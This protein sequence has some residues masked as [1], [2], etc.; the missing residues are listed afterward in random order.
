MGSPRRITGLLAVAAIALVLLSAGGCGGSSESTA[1][2]GETEAA[3]A[4]YRDYLLESAEKLTT[5][6]TQLRNK[7]KL[8]IL[9]GAESRYSSSL[10]P[11]G[12]LRPALPLFPSLSKRLVD[13]KAGAFP[14]I[15]RILWKEQETGHRGVVEAGR[16]REAV[17]LLHEQAKTVPLHTSAI[18]ANAEG[19]LREIADVDL[20][21]RATPYAQI[22]LNPTS[23]NLE[24]VEAAY[25]AVKP[26]A[27][28]TDPDLAKEISREFKAAFTEL[29]RYGPPAHNLK[30]IRPSSPGTAFITTENEQIKPADLQPLAKH[31]AHL[32]SL[33]K[34][35][36]AAVE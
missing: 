11:L 32:Q 8:E 5:W 31:I 35:L 25:A 27:L 9:G 33:F 7:F 4:A 24:G 14:R 16:A 22:D 12:H 13:T 15:E 21:L 20:R 26:L 3:T 10:V 34:E 17:L 30:Q 2:A 36:S 6:T 23:A 19:T 28:A 1:S 18:L 29:E